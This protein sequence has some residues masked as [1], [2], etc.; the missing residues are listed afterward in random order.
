[1]T[2]LMSTKVVAICRS[3]WVRALEAFFSVFILILRATGFEALN[4]FGGAGNDCAG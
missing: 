4:F 2:A 1:M 3:K